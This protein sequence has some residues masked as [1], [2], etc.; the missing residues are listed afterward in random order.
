MRLERARMGYSGV[1][2]VVDVGGYHEAK[3]LRRE[4][5]AGSA[6][7]IKV[8]ETPVEMEGHSADPGRGKTFRTRLVD[9]LM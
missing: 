1:K 4:A 9:F 3:V 7:S 8:S 5:W 6:D 2:E